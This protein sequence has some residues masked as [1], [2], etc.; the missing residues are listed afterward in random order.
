[1]LECSRPGAAVAG[2]MTGSRSPRAAWKTWPPMPGR[3][4]P[5]DWQRDIIRHDLYYT[6]KERSSRNVQHSGL[7]SCPDFPGRGKRACCPIRTLEK[8]ETSFMAAGR[9]STCY[10]RKYTCQNRKQ[11]RRAADTRPGGSGRPCLAAGAAGQTWQP[12]P[13]NCH[14]DDVGRF[15]VAS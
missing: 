9:P 12:M 3:V 13:C 10:E 2:T 14:R 7:F 8:E 6:R 4:Y 11:T 1:M 5:L 15:L